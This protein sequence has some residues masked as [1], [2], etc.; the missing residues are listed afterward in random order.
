VACGE[1]EPCLLSSIESMPEEFRMAITAIHPDFELRHS[2]M[3]G[4]RYFMN[5]CKCGAH[6]GDFYLFSEPGGAFF[7]IDDDDAARIEVIQLPF[8]GDYPFACSMGV[9]PGDI[10]LKHGKRVSWSDLK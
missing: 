10:I 5:T 9:G 4:S 6:F 7:P 8:Q 3:A 2:K 1:E